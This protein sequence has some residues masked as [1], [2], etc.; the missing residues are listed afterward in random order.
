MSKTVDNGN[1]K[2]TVDYVIQR[3]SCE[4]LL[5]ETL[6]ASIEISRTSFSVKD[7]LSL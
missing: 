6:K 2:A 5:K 7:G 1:T 3:A 4:E